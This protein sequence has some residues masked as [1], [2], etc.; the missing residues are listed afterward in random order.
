V[1]SCCGGLIFRK[2]F[3]P[4]ALVKRIS[5]PLFYFFSIVL[6]IKCTHNE[7]VVGNFLSTSNLSSSKQNEKENKEGGFKEA[8][9]F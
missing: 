7:S 3:F 8:K 4:P 2:I 1:G 9:D 6:K 5:Y